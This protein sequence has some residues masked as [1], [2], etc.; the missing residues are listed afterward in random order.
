M[1]CWSDVNQDRL[2][3]FLDMPHGA[4]SQDVHLSV[5]G[6][7]EPTAFQGLFV[8]GEAGQLGVGGDPKHIAIDD[9]TSR[10]SADGVLDCV[11]IHT[12]SAWL[13]GAGLVLGQVQMREKSNEIIAIPELPEVLSLR[14]AT[15]TI[16]SIEDRLHEVLDMAFGDAQAR[17]RARNAAANMTTLRHLSSRPSRRT[18][19][20]NAPSPTRGEGLP[21]T[22]RA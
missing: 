19:A 9:K 15:V 12:V 1:A 16:D 18:R 22:A 20:E 11:A 5:L 7:L 4:S 21:S 10:R 14:G 6:A 17:H 3:G 8:L 13:S 2:A